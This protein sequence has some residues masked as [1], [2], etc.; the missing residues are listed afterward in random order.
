MGIKFFLKEIFLGEKFWGACFG[1]VDSFGEEI[2]PAK[3]LENFLRVKSHSGEEKNTGKQKCFEERYGEQ[4][5]LRV[6]FYLLWFLHT[7]NLNT[8]VGKML[9]VSSEPFPTLV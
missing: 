4:N 2:L 1:G 5:I 9:D 8:S 6:R 3:F 7:T